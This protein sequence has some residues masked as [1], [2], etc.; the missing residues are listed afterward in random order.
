MP[1]LFNIV[2]RFTDDDVVYWEKDPTRDDPFGKPMY[3]PP[4]N[5]KLRWE[6][7][8]IEIIMDDGRK[9]LA[10]AYLLSAYSLSTGDIVW[11]G[12]LATWQASSIYPLIPKMNQGGYEII[13][14]NNTPGIA[15]L[16]GN[17]FEAYL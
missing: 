17:V 12:T 5:R 9:V 8:F 7:T 13:K 1:S 10:K 4:I 11:K 14:V 6:D 16:P 2:S 15:Q 3:L